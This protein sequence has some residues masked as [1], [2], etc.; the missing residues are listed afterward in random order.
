M[1]PERL[2]LHVDLGLRVVA[3]P[4]QSGVGLPA[5]AGAP[6]GRP[7]TPV[8]PTPPP[9]AAPLARPAIAPP[10]HSPP[11]RAAGQPMNVDLVH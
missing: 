1:I 7:Q 6:A 8:R 2:V 3:T 9:P 11:A 10:A 5:R 4:D